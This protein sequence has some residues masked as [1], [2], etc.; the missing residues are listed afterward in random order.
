M[1]DIFA[2]RFR[3]AR[4]SAGLTLDDIAEVCHNR[5]GEA[6]S[7][8]AIAQW[9]KQNGTRPS[10]EN[11]IAAARRLGVSIDY[12]TGLTNSPPP[13]GGLHASEEVMHYRALSQEAI[14]L[15]EQWDRLP[16][17]AQRALQDLLASMKAMGAPKRK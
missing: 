17:S 8:A 16:P 13:Y 4:K 11:L 6:P 14:R 12:L 7:R 15:A 10:F 9:E 1:K 2:E 3:A 5:A